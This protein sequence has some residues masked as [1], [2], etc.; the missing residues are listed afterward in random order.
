MYAPTLSPCERIIASSMRTTEP[1]PFVPAM[2][3]TGKPR[4][5]LP[6]VARNGRKRDKPRRMPVWARRLRT[7]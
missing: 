2:W 1:F 3:T 4:C 5:G 7:G 6:S